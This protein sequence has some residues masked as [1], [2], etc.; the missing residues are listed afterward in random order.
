MSGS[1]KNATPEEIKATF[2]RGMRKGRERRKL[3]AMLLKH[4]F[5]GPNRYR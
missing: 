1:I 5:K 3:E 4:G 2:A